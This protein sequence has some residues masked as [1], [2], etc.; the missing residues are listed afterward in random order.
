MLLE[1]FISCGRQALSDVTVWVEGVVGTWEVVEVAKGEDGTFHAS[2]DTLSVT[3]S[4]EEVIR[5]TRALGDA[6]EAVTEVQMVLSSTSST[7]QSQLPCSDGP[8][9]VL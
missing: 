6:H 7:P 2:L 4:Q 3:T 1:L 8:S 9:S 5:I